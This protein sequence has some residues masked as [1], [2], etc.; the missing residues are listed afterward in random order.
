V[1][2]PLDLPRRLAASVGNSIDAAAEL[3]VF[4]Q[5]VLAHLGSMDQA[6]SEH[7]S[8]MDGGIN[9]L[10]QLIEPMRR[11]IADLAAR[12]VELER[13]TGE[14]ERRIGSLEGSVGHDLSGQLAETN[15]AMKRVEAL[16]ARIAERVPDPDAPGPIAKAKEAITGE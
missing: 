3:P 11:D 10:R 5:K 7:L 1:A 14:L 9:G 4:Q 16:V 8:S 6:M 12:A 15:G 2:S 13:A